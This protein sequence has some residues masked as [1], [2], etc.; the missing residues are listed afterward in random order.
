LF[1]IVTEQPAQESVPAPPISPAGSTH[2]LP[3]TS[4]SSKWHLS[5]RRGHTAMVSGIRSLCATH[6]QIILAWTGDIEASPG[7]QS[8]K[9]LVPFTSLSQEDKKELEGEIGKYQSPLDPREGKKR[10]NYVPVFLDD[11]IAHGH[12]EGYCKTGK[13]SPPIIHQ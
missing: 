13:R 3:E 8:Q 1:S 2:S 11:K 9:Q 5:P 12:Y 6:E 4:S 7:S 10:I